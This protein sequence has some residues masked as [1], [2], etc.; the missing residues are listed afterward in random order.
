MQ[1]SRLRNRLLAQTGHYRAATAY[2]GVGFQ[3]QWRVVGERLEYG[4]AEA[5]ELEWFGLADLRKN[6]VATVSEFRSS[7]YVVETEE[8]VW[9]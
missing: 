6:A 2:C 8:R 5:A 4:G 7:T 9:S 1:S 3:K